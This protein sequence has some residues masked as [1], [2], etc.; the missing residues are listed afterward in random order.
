MEKMCHEYEMEYEYV[1]AQDD[2][3]YEE[4]KWF[5]ATHSITEL[6]TIM[7]YNNNNEIILVEWFK[8][9]WYFEE[10]ICLQLDDEKKD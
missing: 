10:F 2:K 8:L 5:L 4:R 9:P 1:D 7:I 6:P 3:Q